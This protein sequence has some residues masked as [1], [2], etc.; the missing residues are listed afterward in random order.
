MFI[1]VASYRFF[2]DFFGIYH[3][4]DTYKDCKKLCWRSKIRSNSSKSKITITSLQKLRFTGIVF[5]LTIVG[6]QA[7]IK[8][9][10]GPRHFV[11]FE[12]QNF[13]LGSIQ[14]HCLHNVF[15]RPLFLNFN[16]HRPHFF[17]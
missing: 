2:F 8:G 11:I 16:H 12:E 5:A 1:K 15:R 13:L 3:L 4:F 17:S 6:S 14:G 9:L 7:R 10:V